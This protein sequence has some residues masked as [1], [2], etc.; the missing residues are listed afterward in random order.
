[1]ES[2]EGTGSYI[3]PIHGNLQV[4]VTHCSLKVFLMVCWFTRNNI[5]DLW[6]KQYKQNS[7]LLC[8]VFSTERLKK[9]KRV[10]EH[11]IQ[12]LTSKLEREKEVRKVLVIIIY[13]CSFA[14]ST[15]T[16]IYNHL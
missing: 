5:S 8:D 2:V 6:I 7:S 4:N 13:N 10:L 1:M 9:R 15:V 16:C 14:A 3:L 11:Q 12:V